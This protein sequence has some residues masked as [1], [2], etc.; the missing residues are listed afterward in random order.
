MLF[1]AEEGAEDHCQLGSP[2]LSAQR[3]FDWLHETLGW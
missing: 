3:T 2:M 1:S